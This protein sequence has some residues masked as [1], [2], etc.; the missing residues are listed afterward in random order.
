MSSADRSEVH[1]GGCQCGAVRYHATGKPVRVLACHCTSCKLRTGAE[2]G[3]GV[4]YDDAAVG[5]E[6]ITM[7]TY[8]F[9][10]DT[11]GRW[12]R[13]EFCPRCG[14]CVTWTTQMRPGLRAIAGG[15]FDDPNWFSIE[16]HIWTRS[17]RTDMCF[18][19]DVPVH[20]Q[21]LP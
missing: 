6:G 8:E 7:H 13:N 21:A 5:F 18:P 10:S 12:L 3:I 2:F 16:A 11:S 17:A 20:D 9:H 1:Q 15:T 14:T 19:D 4:Y